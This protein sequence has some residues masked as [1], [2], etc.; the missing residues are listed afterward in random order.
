MRACRTILMSSEFIISLYPR[1]RSNN[2]NASSFGR[3]NT[4]IHDPKI[5]TTL[6][7]PLPLT[8]V[9]AQ[10][11]VKMSP[12]E[13]S[14]S[15]PPSW[16]VAISLFTTSP[17]CSQIR[18]RASLVNFRCIQ[19]YSLRL[20]DTRNSHLLATHLISTTSRTAPLSMS[21]F[22]ISVLACLP[23]SPEVASLG[24]THWASLSPLF[25]RMHRGK[26][27]ATSLLGGLLMPKFTSHVFHHL[28]LEPLAAHE[29]H[30][31]ERE[32]AAAT[33]HQHSSIPSSGKF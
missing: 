4:L 8:Y 18:V 3:W 17:P 1:S 9:L 22:W 27:V 25:R 16:T 23:M 19:E 29:P 12:S 20:L 33:N 31:T 2:C 28:P 6:R 32:W 26:I 30:W 7:L 14:I 15:R 21:A 13:I 11:L 24:S 10:L 5:S